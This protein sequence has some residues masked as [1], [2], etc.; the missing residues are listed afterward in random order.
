MELFTIQKNFQH[1]ITIEKSRFICNLQKVS[2]EQE[3]VATITLFK[4]QYYD[5]SHNCIAYIIG[6]NKQLQKS[7]D[8][9]EPSG[10]AGQPILEVLRKR[11]LHNTLAIVTRYFGGIKLGSGGLIRAYG[12]SVSEA[13][14]LC[15]VAQKQLFYDVSFQEDNQSVG[16]ALN[17][18]YETKLF[19][20]LEIDYTNNVIINIRV[21][22]DQLDEVQTFLNSIFNT[23]ISLKITKKHYIEVPI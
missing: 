21:K 8:D 9:G 16:K 17:F 13:I 20:I 10:T 4:K 15:G 7:S 23:K 5:A 11:S 6:E 19:K 2:T 3:A 18:L 12:K 14:E 22:N 1:E